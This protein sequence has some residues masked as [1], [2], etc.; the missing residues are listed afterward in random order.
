MSMQDRPA[1]PGRTKPVPA[2]DTGVDPIDYRP[3]SQEHAP[4]PATSTSATTP[5]EGKGTPRVPA[6][7]PTPPASTS[8]AA[9]AIIGTATRG[10]EQTVQLSTRVSPDVT[11]IIDQAAAATGRSK[12]D[13][14]E[15]A[16]RNAAWR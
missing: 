6:A 4:A 14:V 9:P 8:T 2:A 5:V 10:R 1:R 3:T 15:E 16:I 12:R 13:L 11:D 7:A